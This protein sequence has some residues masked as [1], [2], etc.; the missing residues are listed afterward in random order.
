MFECPIHCILRKLSPLPLLLPLFFPL[1]VPA[2]IGE[3]R[4]GIPKKPTRQE[5][6]GLSTHTLLGFHLGD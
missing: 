5:L 4:D 6:F 1:Q 2:L 3:R